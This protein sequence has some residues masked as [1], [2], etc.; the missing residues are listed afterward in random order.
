[1]FSDSVIEQ[2]QVS[3]NEL[4]SA[5]D[6]LKVVSDAMDMD[7]QSS[8]L[9]EISRIDE[10]IQFVTDTLI[11]GI[12]IAYVAIATGYV[13]DDDEGCRFGQVEWVTE[14]YSV[15]CLIARVMSDG[16]RFSFHANPSGTQVFI[17]G[18]SGHLH[19]DGPEW[20]DPHSGL[21]LVAFSTKE[22]AKKWSRG[23]C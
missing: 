12:A 18:Y 6:R 14:I 9:L 15:S 23:Y 16:S 17:E 10:L 3:L 7:V 8:F 4:C 20:Q 1:M 2:F 19:V 13:D 5:R 11:N 21:I 22:R